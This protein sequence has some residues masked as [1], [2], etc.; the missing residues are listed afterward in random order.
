M[1]QLERAVSKYVTLFR[2]ELAPGRPC[3]ED[4]RNSRANGAFLPI[5]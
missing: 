4:R 1:Y 5:N 3:P 2:I